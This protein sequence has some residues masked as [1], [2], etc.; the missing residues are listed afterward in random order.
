MHLIAKGLFGCVSKEFKSVFNTQKVHLKEKKYPF[1]NK[2]K[3][4]ES[5]FK[6]LKSLKIIK[7]IKKYFL[8]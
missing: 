8:T 6:S 3:K 1:N 5:T 2:K 4:N 7:T